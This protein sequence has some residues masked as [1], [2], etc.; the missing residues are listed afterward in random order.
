MAPFKHHLGL[1]S[2]AGKCRPCVVISGGKCLKPSK[3]SYSM[4]SV[5]INCDMLHFMLYG[6]AMPWTYYGRNRLQPYMTRYAGVM[7]KRDEYP[8]VIAAIDQIITH[9]KSYSGEFNMDDWE[10]IYAKR[11]IHK[12]ITPSGIVQYEYDITEDQW[13]S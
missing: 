7:C 12:Y 8:E 10:H 2:C 9:H 3:R 13:K 4:E 6:E 11:R 1:G 5:G